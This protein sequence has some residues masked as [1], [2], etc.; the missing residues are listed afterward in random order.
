MQRCVA[1]ARLA[2]AQRETISAK[3]RAQYVTLL[4]DLN[5]IE[6]ARVPEQPVRE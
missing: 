5:L 6:R 1:L 2:G 3:S 4:S